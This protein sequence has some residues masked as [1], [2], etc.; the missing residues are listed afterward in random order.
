M[1]NK[2]NISA[3]TEQLVKAVENMTL[4]DRIA[5]LLRVNPVTGKPAPKPTPS[6][7]R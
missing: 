2:M 3:A 1:E 4:T 5:S 6:S 7:K